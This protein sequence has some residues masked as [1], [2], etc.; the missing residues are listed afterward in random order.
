MRSIAQRT[1]YGAVEGIVA[2]GSAGAPRSSPGAAQRFAD[3]K[4]LDGGGS[5]R[6]KIER[7]VGRAT[8]LRQTASSMAVSVTPG[9]YTSL[10]ECVWKAV[11]DL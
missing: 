7:S 8:K 4:G 2:K 6:S 10:T 11:G 5:D 1:T 9:I 3:G